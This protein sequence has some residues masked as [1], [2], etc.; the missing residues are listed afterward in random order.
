MSRELASSTRKI[1][2]SPSMENILLA[3]LAAFVVLNFRAEFYPSLIVLGIET[4]IYCSIPILLLVWLQKRFADSE[5]ITQRRW[6]F[7]LQAGAVLFALLPFL[8]QTVLRN[9]SLGDAWEIVVLS[10]VLNAAWYSAVFSKLRGFDRVAFLLGSFLVLF[11]CFMTQN[12]ATY[13]FAFLY[14]AASLWWLLG[15][16]WNRVQSKAVDIESRSLPVRGL[17]IVITIPFLLTAAALASLFGPSQTTISLTGF[18]PSSGGESWHDTYARSGVGDGDML[19]AGENA[20]SV[21]PVESDQFIE[22][23]KPSIYDIMSEKYE[24]PVRKKNQKNRAQEIDRLASHMH[25]AVQSEQSGRSFRTVRKVTKEKKR[26]L[27]DRIA[28]ALFFVEGEV[29]V[30]FGIDAFYHFD[31]WDWTKPEMGEEQILNP[32][33]EVQTKF[34]KPWFVLRSMKREFLTAKRAHRV[35]ILRLDSA[36]LPA[37]PLLKSWHIPLVKQKH[38]FR[39]SPQA[40][41]VMAGDMIPSHTIIDMVSEIPNHH[42][43]RDGKNL[44]VPDYVDNK[45]GIVDKLLGLANQGGTRTGKYSPLEEDPESPYRQVPDNDTKLRLEKMVDDLTADQSIGWKQVDAIVNHLRNNFE[46]DPTNVPPEDCEDSV[47][48]FLDQQAGPAYLFATTAT[49]MLRTAGYRTRMRSGFLVS[50]D[51]YDR[52]ARQSIVDSSNVHMWPEV[53]IDGWN[54]LPVE[55]TPGYPIPCNVQTMWQWAKVTAV[56]CINLLMRNPITTLAVAALSFFLFWF[57]KEMVVTFSW[58]LWNVGM[59]LPGQRIKLTRKLIDRRFWAAGMPRPN[60][61]S[62]GD[63]YSRVD[64]NAA[65]EFVKHWCSLNFSANSNVDNNEL[66]LACKQI[67]S[68]LTYQRIRVFAKD[69]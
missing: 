63:W 46:L 61:V 58:L 56:N 66:G 31:G 51:D 30:R 48:S 20:S 18:M 2:A 29:P 68:L 60:F 40:T 6:V 54:W 39:W 67:V 47:G 15:N 22:D 9:F 25:N 19:T 52:V 50:H 7:G 55:P 49:Q 21:G 28:K 69:H 42:T 17:A 37:P 65:S 13:V 59:L 8:M 4:A 41:V 44:L 23:D 5:F 32:P 24:G 64:T 11:V 43:L 33:F 38:L 35:K 57:R 12:V 10:M 16:Y 3:L 26:K 36:T 27:D 1:A 45:I 62:I 14:L 34:G 53:C